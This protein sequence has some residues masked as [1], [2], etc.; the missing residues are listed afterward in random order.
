MIIQTIGR[1]AVL[2]NVASEAAKSMYEVL[3]G[4]ARQLRCH[5]DE[6]HLN[7]EWPRVWLP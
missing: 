6:I 5:N 3:L 7:P 1:N 4:I 2:I